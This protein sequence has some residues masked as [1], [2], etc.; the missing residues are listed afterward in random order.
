M[1]SVLAACMLGY[2]YPRDAEALL[3][4]VDLTSRRLMQWCSANV[5]CV[6]GIFSGNRQILTK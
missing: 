2:M 1:E 3:Y 4:E 6:A 5:L